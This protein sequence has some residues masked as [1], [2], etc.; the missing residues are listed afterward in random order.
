MGERLHE[1]DGAALRLGERVAFLL[2]LKGPPHA[3]GN[4]H[5]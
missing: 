2:L 5:Q 1:D 4:V 3:A